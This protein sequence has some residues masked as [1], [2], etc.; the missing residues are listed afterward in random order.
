MGKKCN[1]LNRFRAFALFVF[2]FSSFALLA[3]L[4]PPVVC[5]RTQS[6]DDNRAHVLK[7]S[8]IL[9]ITKGAE[10]AWKQRRGYL[11][12]QHARK[13]GGTSLCMT[14]RDNTK[15]LITAASSD[16]EPPLKRESCQIFK[17]CGIDCNLKQTLI[18][19]NTESLAPILR[20]AM[21]T[22][23]RNFIEV[24]GCGVP[25]D[26][27]SDQWSDFVFI[28]SIR[29]PMAR[30][31]SSLR[32]DFRYK[33]CTNG[34]QKDP[35]S[36][37]VRFIGTNNAILNQCSKGIYY[38]MSN[39]FVRMFSGMEQ[40]Y[41]T[42]EDMLMRAKNNWNRFSCVVLQ[43]EWSQTVHCIGN[44]LGLY[45]YQ[46]VAFNVNGDPRPVT[47]ASMASNTG[48][49]EDLVREDDYK[50]LLSLNEVDMQFY[51]WAKDQI[52]QSYSEIL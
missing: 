41:T 25:D 21:Q 23:S 46:A 14:L 6:T 37:L 10:Q 13:A 2:A 43:E 16:H 17:L 27:L 39:Y 1:F 3:S 15:G 24:E 50:R 40:N 30:I 36:C 51:E 11:W 22:T 42:D 5:D 49:S 44:R 45:R 32:N 26:I 28:S 38:C 4:R 52:V 31:E 9:N 20:K 47:N 12:L 7:D 33:T 18:N 19:N 8:H 35:A 34:T 48:R 29:H